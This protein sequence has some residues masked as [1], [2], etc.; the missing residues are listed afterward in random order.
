MALLDLR[1]AAIAGATVKTFA[2]PLECVTIPVLT[3]SAASRRGVYS[4]VLE[5]WRSEG[6]RGLF[7]GSVLDVLRGGAARGITVGLVD[8][9]KQTL[10]VSDFVAGAIAGGSQTML[11]YPL[12][13]VQTVRRASIRSA[14]AYVGARGVVLAGGV[15]TAEML[16]LM[17]TR[18][19]VRGL[20]PALGPS[21]VGFSSFYAI[22]FGAREPVREATGSTF[23]AGFIG[24]ALACTLCGWN[25]VVRL[26]MQRRAIEG[27][28][29][30]RRRSWRET[31]AE[32][33]AAGG[34]GRL[35]AGFGVKVVQTGATMGLTLLV[36][37]WLRAGRS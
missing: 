2:A 14:P 32:E 35:Y 7:K 33:Y 4:I 18:Q 8:S 29:A 28:C 30:Q 31:L 22:Q 34:I 37:D 15:N 13:V 10:G 23:A 20:Y 6:W 17:A 36:Y 16:W 5:I 1:D 9:C 19:G 11:L 12:E 27:A 21:L 26:T 25:N 3:C 24:S